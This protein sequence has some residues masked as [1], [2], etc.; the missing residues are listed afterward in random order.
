M[1]STPIIYSTAHLAHDGL[2]EIEDGVPIPCHER[3]ERATAILGALEAVG[4]YR[5]EAPSDHGLGPILAVHDQDLVAFLE[6]VWPEAVEA[7]VTDGTR[8][9]IP[10][11]F[12]TAAYV[13]GQASWQ[14]PD[15]GPARL[16]AFCFDT[17]TPIVAG[18]YAAARGAVDVALSAA[19]WVLAGARLAYG[20]CRPPGHHAGRALFG[21]Y[22]FF[23]NAA[24]VAQRLVEGGASRVAILDLDYHHGNGTQQIFWERGDVLYVSLHADPRRA[25][26][27]FS[28]HAA[29]KGSGA[30][31]GTNANFPLAARTDV[32]AYAAALGDALQRIADFAPDAPL[33]LSLGFDTFE[34]DPIGDFALRT[35]D[36]AR[37]GRMV[38]TVGVPVV[39]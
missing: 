1:T 14:L 24:I 37:I 16:G 28:G 18:T 35:P 32:D 20:L 6:A 23:N 30:G 33:V 27:Y 7:G 38:G 13:Q 3:P 10:D 34:G 31:A 12:R 2:I 15:S 39:A 36:Y 29:E 9:L 5:I 21:G 25:Y 17:A 8:S 26:P 4:G 22:C 11:T 19:E